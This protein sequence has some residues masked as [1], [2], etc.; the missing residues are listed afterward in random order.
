MARVLLT[1][2]LGEGLGHLSALLPVVEGLCRRGHLVFA[3]LKDL[4][5]AAGVFRAADVTYLQ[6]PIK[7]RPAKNRISPSRTFAQILHNVGFGDPEEL[8]V[9][10][11]A[12]RNLYDSVQ[13]DLIV[14][15]HSPTA[16]LAARSYPARKATIGTGFCCPAD[17]CP[18]PDLSR[19]RPE[20]S[21]Q[22]QRHEQFVLRN[23]NLELGSYGQPP[24]QRLSQLYGEVD[25]CFLMTFK[26]LDTYP[27]R[28]GVEYWGTWPNLPGT[29]P[30]WPEGRGKR[31]YAYLK[32][33][34]AMPKVLDLLNELRCPTLVYGDRLNPKVPKRY[35]SE[36]LRFEDRPL[37]LDQIGRQCDLAILNG[38]HGTT[39]SILL[40]GKPALLMPLHLEQA[41]NSAAV[42]RLGAGL[43]ASIVKPDLLGE[44]IDSLLSSD[45][46]TQAACRFAARYA[47]CRTDQQTERI[48]RRAVE[49]LS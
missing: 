28:E 9:M 38:T 15:D 29:T 22:V 49:L 23:V 1:W 14:F 32:P 31:V 25:E 42:V 41:A 10:A 33:F 11:E 48:I 17:V 36:T 18:M 34:P 19:G 40:A 4:P 30:V 3:A 43:R 8:R 35:Q 47:D 7:I 6:A 44:Q 5:R 26:E 20:V 46:Y 2:E 21:Q 16:L 27:E 12:W 45:V 37:D 13:P 24:L 39:A